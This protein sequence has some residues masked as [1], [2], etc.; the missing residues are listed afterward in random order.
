M[1][2]MKIVIIDYGLGNLSSVQRALEYCGANVSITKS[3]DDIVKAQKL[4][5]PGVGAFP[6]GM[7]QLQSRKYIEP[8]LEKV[9]S[10]IPILGICLGMQL[11]G[12][13][14]EEFQISKGL[15]LMPY[16]V[17]PI[18]KGMENGKAR[19]LPSIGWSK[20]NMNPKNLNNKI[21]PNSF[22]NEYFYFVHS[23]H[24]TTNIKAHILARYNY[25]GFTINAAIAHENIMGVQFHPEK[26]GKSG[27]RFLQ[28]FVEFDYN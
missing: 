17:V 1:S 12:I 5:L 28:N 2:R 20:I 16:K 4:I 6:E 3:L 15:G 23:F 21:L 27:L 22:E 14:S 10:G 9:K 11:L 7:K 25:Q 19:K 26:S 13:S 18:P 8:I 24:A